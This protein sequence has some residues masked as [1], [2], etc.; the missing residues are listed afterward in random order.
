MRLCALQASNDCLGTI[1]EETAWRDADGQAWDVCPP[2]HEW[3]R[4]ETVR[5]AFEHVEEEDAEVLARL[6]DD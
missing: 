2:C 6:G 3:E 5:R 4:R 1:T